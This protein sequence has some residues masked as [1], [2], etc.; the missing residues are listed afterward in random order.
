MSRNIIGYLKQVF[1][2]TTNLSGNDLSESV[3]D[4][5]KQQKLVEAFFYKIS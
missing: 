3:A 5:Q 4:A 1:Y 2:N